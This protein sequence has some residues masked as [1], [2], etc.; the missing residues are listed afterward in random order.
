MQNL[1]GLVSVL[2][3]ITSRSTD[4]KEEMIM[5]LTQRMTTLGRAHELVRLFRTAG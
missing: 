1:L 2:T 3:Q 5:Q 4:T